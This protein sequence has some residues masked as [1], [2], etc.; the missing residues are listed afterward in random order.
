MA[1]YKLDFIDES[2]L[3]KENYVYRWINDV[4]GRLRMATKMD[5]YDVVSAGELGPGFSIENTDSEG[6]DTIRMYTGLEG[7]QPVHAIL[8][9]KPREFWEADNEEV[10]SKRDAMMQGRVYRGEADGAPSGENVPSGSDLDDSVAYVPA[11]VKMG[12]SAQR[13]R[14]PTS[15]R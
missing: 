6:G 9:K 12:G 4:P 15:F 5:D 10:V 8:C 14:A 7:G 3:D 1:Q 13:K 11:G 2:L